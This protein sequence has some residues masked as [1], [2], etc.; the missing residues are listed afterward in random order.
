VDLAQSFIV[1]S[2]N[3]LTSLLSDRDWERWK[4]K[5]ELV[6]LKVGEVLFDAGQPIRHI[7][8]PL[9][10]IISQQ[11]DF[12]DGKSAEFAQ[13][14]NE[15]MV[16]VFIFM[17]S[18]S[19]SS[20][21]IVVASGIAYRLPA[22]W[23]L[24]EF[25]SSGMFRQL[26]L[27]YMQILMTHASQ[28]AVCNRRHSIDQQLCR[29][30]LLQLDRVAGDDLSLTHELMSRSMGVRREGVSEAA[31]R[32]EKIGAIRYSRGHIQVLDRAALLKN[33]CEC[34]AIIKRED[35]RLFPSGPP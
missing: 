32:L 5:I 16:G 23:M 19:T 22:D 4:T 21:A 15:G 1:K 24:G 7:Y 6:N 13:M 35:R 33:S 18:A 25:N 10:G 2:G 3:R 11:Y 31:K 27:H 26:I 14:G 12:E 34:Y 30:L 8:F 17:G 20:K 28:L 9:T 29:T